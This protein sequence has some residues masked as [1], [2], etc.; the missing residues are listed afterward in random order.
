MSRAAFV[1]V[2][3]LDLVLGVGLVF[4]LVF[5]GIDWVVMVSSGA[6]TTDGARI[7]ERCASPSPT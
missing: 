2:S 4:D 1:G 6:R 7:T 5:E 3:V